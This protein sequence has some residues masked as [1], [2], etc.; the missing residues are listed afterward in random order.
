[1]KKVLLCVLLILLLCA[2]WMTALKPEASAGGVDLERAEGYLKTA[3]EQYALGGYGSAID[4]ATAAV[5]CADTLENELFLADCYLADGRTGDYRSCLE[6]VIRLWPEDM[7]AYALLS[8][9]YLEAGNHPDCAEVCRKAYQ[10]GC[11]TEELVDRYF[12]ANYHYEL[13]SGALEAAGDFH[14]GLA[15]VRLEDGWYYLNSSMRTVAGPLEAASAPLG[16]VLGYR[17][18]GK[19]GFFTADGAKYMD[20]E[21]EFDETW[22]LCDGLALTRS[23]SEYT[24]VDRGCKPKLGVFSDASCFAGGVAAI[25]ISG[26]WQLIDA[27]GNALASGLADVKLDGERRCSVGGRIFA[28]TGSGYDLYDA[29]GALVAKTGFADARPFAG[30]GAAAVFNGT[31]WGFV[32]ADGTMLLDFQYADAR[33]FADGLAA[34]Q[35]D[36]KWGFITESGRVVIEPVFADAG[37]FTSGKL[38]PVLTEDGWH[39]IARN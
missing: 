8:A 29:S 2:G 21:Q 36:G 34:V 6:R 26:Q 28:S 39:Y 20:S 27:A 12:T 37:S 9:R 35:I 7:R 16:S 24:F 5:N 30:D 4:Y 17:K 33:S 31:A 14:D 10:T 18:D 1:M 3:R 38:A 23:G 25:Q 15:L 13:K 22:A 19:A 32:K 11:A